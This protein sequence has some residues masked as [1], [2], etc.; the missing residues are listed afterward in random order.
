MGIQERKV[1][2]K[3]ARQSAILEAAKGIFFKKGFQGTTMDQI[4]YA[5]ELSKGSLYNYF[6]SKEDLYVTLV[7]E[8]FEILSSMLTKAAVVQSPWDQKLEILGRTYY[9]FFLKYPEYFHVLFF[10]QHDDL[11]AKVS[12]PL[13]DAC[14][15]EG[16][17]ILSIIA[18]AIQEG[19]DYEEIDVQK[20]INKFKSKN[21]NT[22]LYY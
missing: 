6:P 11:G 20:F 15:E 21:K 22:F 13:Y 9:G 16:T 3:K 17:A 8:G 7:L 1:R 4:A 14:F 12:Q 19:I 2:E 18:K 10:M 5:A